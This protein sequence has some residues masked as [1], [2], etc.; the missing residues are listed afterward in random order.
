MTDAVIAISA[1]VIGK[2][3]DSKAQQKIIDAELG[4]IIKNI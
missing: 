3:L 4:L 1:K 2:T